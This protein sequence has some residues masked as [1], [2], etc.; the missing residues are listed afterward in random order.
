[1]KTSLTLS[2]LG[3]YNALM[4]VLM[5]FLPDKMAITM[6]GTSRAEE[7]PDLEQLATMFHY[8]LAPALLMIGL[9]LIMI[10]KCDM[11]TA[12]KSLLAYV[13]ATAVLLTLFFTIFSKSTVIDF[14]VEMAVPDILALTLA[15]FGYFKVK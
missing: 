6:I 14:S 4:G 12:K 2:I 1:M 7:N 10:R 11:E 8:G 3:A 5:L 15:L 13:I 9:I